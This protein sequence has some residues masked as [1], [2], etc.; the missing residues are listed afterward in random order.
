MEYRNN[1]D[2]EEKMEL[3]IRRLNDQVKELQ[4]IHIADRA[5]IERLLRQVDNQAMTIV[6]YQEYVMGPL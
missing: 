4:E 5:L 2:F 6:R 1:L 3:Q